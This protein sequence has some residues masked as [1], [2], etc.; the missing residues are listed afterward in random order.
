[1]TNQKKQKRIGIFGG[2]FDP[3][4]CGHLLG[5]ERAREE[6]DLQEVLF[7]PAGNPPHKHYPE[8]ADALDRFDMVRISISDNQFFKISDIEFKREG[9][10]YTIDTINQL[11]P[12][13]GQDCELF[14]IIG[15][16]NV[17]EVLR[18]KNS[19]ELFQKV[20][21]IVLTRPGKWEES[22]EGDIEALKKNNCRVNLVEMPLIHISS[23]EVRCRVAEN[24]SIKYM[25]PDC[26]EKYI[27]EKGLYK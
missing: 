27:G 14:F 11:I 15:A 19:K 26:V 3:I 25:V 7:I 17:A 18:W 22:L 4:Q 23:T 5:A 1:M 16:D 21:F 13:L 12:V 2:T 20:Q 10:S 8:M 24:R 9:L 6:F